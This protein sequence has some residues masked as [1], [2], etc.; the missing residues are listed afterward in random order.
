[1]FLHRPATPIVA[2]I[3]TTLVTV[4]GRMYSVAIFLRGYMFPITS[5]GHYQLLP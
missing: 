5:R 1:M 2:S 3:D 4:F